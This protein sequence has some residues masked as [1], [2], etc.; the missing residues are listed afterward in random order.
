MAE[1]TFRLLLHL[2][3]SN[4]FILG[5]SMGGK[6]VMTMLGM[7]EKKERPLPR[8]QKAIILDIAPVHYPPHYTAIFTAIKQC[9]LSQYRTRSDILAAFMP[10]IGDVASCHLL[11]KNISRHPAGRFQ[12]RCNIEAIKRAYPGIMSVP[13]LHVSLST[14][15]LFI[16]GGQSDYIT[17]H[18]RAYINTLFLHA[19]HRCIEKAGHWVH[20]DCPA[21]VLQHCRDYLK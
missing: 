9:S 2:G 3:L 4:T 17:A 1:D 11:L 7:Q 20:A 14:P 10:T 8:I 15:T 13:P 6:T 19:S 5:H 12:W 18:A 21:D 16:R